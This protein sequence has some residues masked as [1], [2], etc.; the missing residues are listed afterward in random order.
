MESRVRLIAARNS[1]E[2][3]EN[4]ART[5]LALLPEKMAQAISTS[6]LLGGPNFGFCGEKRMFFANV[7]IPSVGVV[8]RGIKKAH[9]SY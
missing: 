5:S 8:G 7:S 6:A 1:S 9:R 3:Q 4:L 2:V